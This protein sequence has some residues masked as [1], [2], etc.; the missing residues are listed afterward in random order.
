MDARN[1]SKTIAVT[2][3]PFLMRAMGF[4]PSEQE[5]RKNENLSCMVYFYI[6]SRFVQLIHIYRNCKS[7]K[8]LSFLFAF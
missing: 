8:L 1:V 2:E 7:F 3:V 4:Y 5:V 6:I